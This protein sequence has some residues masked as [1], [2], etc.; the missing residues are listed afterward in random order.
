M[1]MCWE[2]TS[3]CSCRWI[4]PAGWGRRPGL[5]ERAHDAGLAV[6]AWT[7]RSENAFLPPELRD[8]TAKAGYG[9]AAAEYARF[10]ALGVDGVFTDHPDLAVAAFAQPAVR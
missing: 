8:G 5:V 9:D 10:R 3:P 1:P 6:H 4:R 2:H 7:F